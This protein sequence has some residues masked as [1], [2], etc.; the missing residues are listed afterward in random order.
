MKIIR[1]PLFMR[2]TPESELEQAIDRELRRLPDRRAPETLLPRV[3]QAIAERQRLPWWQKSFAYWPWPARVLFL[4]GTSGLAAFLV[5]FTWGLTS[6]VSLGSL[7]DELG[8][9]SG[10][11]DLVRGL[12]GTLG[13]AVMTLVRS[14]GP[15]LLWGTVGVLGACYLTTMALGTFCWR[16]ASQRI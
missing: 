5:Y 1:H 9:L 11:F 15:W 14:A 3:L 13:G 4:A 16:L 6:G 12:G 10:R 8:Q 7:T 2:P